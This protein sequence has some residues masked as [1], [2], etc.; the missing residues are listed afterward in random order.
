MTFLIV[1]NSFRDT[2]KVT[3]VV[4]YCDTRILALTTDCVKELTGVRF[5]L[6]SFGIV[7]IWLLVLLEVLVHM[8]FER[9]DGI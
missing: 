5:L 6:N 8:A 2:W 1:I 4:M 7:P 3:N 9:N